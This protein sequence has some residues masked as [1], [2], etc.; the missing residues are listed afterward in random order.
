M[1]IWTV[2]YFYEKNIQIF[3]AMQLAISTIARGNDSPRRVSDT[4]K[5]HLKNRTGSMA[6]SQMPPSNYPLFP[7]QH[8]QF[9]ALWSKEQL[10]I[11]A[12]L[13]SG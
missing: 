7:L 6:R 4:G 5:V 2:K 12:H 8:Q 11:T 1:E 9:D 13:N 3:W 10:M